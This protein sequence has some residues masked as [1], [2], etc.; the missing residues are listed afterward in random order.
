ML[1]RQRLG[2]F[3]SKGFVEGYSCLDKPVWQSLTPLWQKGG[4][5]RLAACRLKTRCW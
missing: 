4:G 3:V 5:L 1:N 2:H